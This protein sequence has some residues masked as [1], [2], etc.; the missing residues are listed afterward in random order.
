[1][2]YL[3]AFSLSALLLWVCQRFALRFRW[4]DAPDSRKNHHAPTPAVAGLAWVLSVC[5]VLSLTSIVPATR[6]LVAGTFVL[7]LVGA[8][9]DRSPLPSWLRLLLQS[10][11]VG[12]AF[13]DALP[14]VSLGNLLGSGP[15]LLGALAWP[16]TVFMV[17][18]VINALN[19]IDGMDGLLF[20]VALTALV[21]IAMVAAG[22]ASAQISL[23]AIAALIPFGLINVR[24]PWNARARMFFG[25]AG[26]TSMGLL[27]GW[28]VVQQSQ[29]GFNASAVYPPVTALWLLAVP[30]VDAV[31][32]LI[33]R[34]QH[35]RSPWSAD[36]WHLHHL[37]MDAGL[38]VNRSLAIILALMLSLQLL[39]LQLRALQVPD[40]LQAI[41]FMG[42]ALTYHGYMQRVTRVGRF[43]GRQLRSPIR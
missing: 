28:L 10:M 31:S 22:S 29:S 14:L 2:S 9:D 6:W 1:M 17:V 5:V 33:R 36:R 24:W 13:A 4:L 15:L 20:S 32:L 19:M 41:L 37:L 21:C 16:I 38:S 43:L 23:I 39:G 26:S 8:W 34:A 27:L 42:L 18:G 40:S 35:G 11:A 3:I 25:D 30:L 12:I 7:A